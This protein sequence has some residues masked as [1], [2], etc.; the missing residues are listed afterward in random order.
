MLRPY[1]RLL[2]PFTWMAATDAVAWFAR[3]QVRGATAPITDAWWTVLV[4]AGATGLYVGWRMRKR[5]V[6]AI[7]HA[8][9]CWG[10]GTLWALVAV[11][12][13]PN[14]FLQAVLLAGGL[15]LYRDHLHRHRVTHTGSHVLAGQV[16]SPAPTR[17]LVIG[18][19]PEQAYDT[20]VVT[21]PPPGGY[22]PPDTG[23][24]GHGTRRP[25]GADVLRARIDDVLAEFGL[26]ARVA[27]ATRGPT[28]TR[29]EIEITGPGVRVERVLRL[30]RNFALTAGTPAV[31]MLAPVQGMSRI[32]LEVPNRERDIVALGDVLNSPAAQRDPHPLAVGLGQSVEGTAVMARLDKMP[33]LLIAGATG[34][35]KSAEVNAIIT[36]ILVR[37]TPAQ[38]L[39]LLIDPKRV[40][41]TPYAGVPHLVRPIVTD[42]PKAAAALGWVVGEM[43]ARYD[44]MEAA[45][46]RDIA[47]YNLNHP[48]RPYPYLVVIVDELADLMMVAA[49][50]GDDGLEI[51]KVEDCIVRIGQLA[52]AAG[53]HLVLATQRPSVDVV[54]GL[55]KANIPARLAFATASGTDSRVILDQTGAE[56]LA[57]QGDGLFRPSDAARPLR[58]QGAFV[59]EKEI[60]GIVARC[61]RQGGLVAAGRTE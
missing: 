57:G 25:A 46:V 31:R 37:A 7:A 24:L 60:R 44:A 6:A 42:A 33:H 59:T 54:T 30:E 47:T 21:D 35:G 32:G 4:V 43:D 53:I 17:P 52:R 20:P 49:G 27:S 51:P 19:P 23:T 22:A 3:Y 15:W 18:L 2:A 48:D 11:T 41:L 9:R 26:D 61:R 29:Y 58:I 8:I 14:W 45:G 55:I 13:T 40:E 12:W 28:V 5:R 10:Y 56:K 1:R 36:S 50:I 38:V 34:A 39:L 16:T